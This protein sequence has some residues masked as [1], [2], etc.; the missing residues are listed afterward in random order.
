MKRAD[1][2][3][4]VESMSNEIAED[5]GFEIV[6]VEYV[7]EGA[8]M[9]LKV[10]IDKPGGINIDDCQLFSQKLNPI[11]D[12]KDPIKEYYF[13]EVSSPGLNRPLK[14]DKDFERSIGSQVEIGL[15]APIDGS[16]S[17]SGVLLEYDGDMIV[18]EDESSNRV[19]IERKAIAKINLTVE[20]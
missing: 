3:K 8:D 16:K 20:F 15:Y 18:I 9:Y 1:I 14:K 7:K 6:D 2:E 17:Y 11:L 12:E 4:L 5:L 13:L 10:Y 19:E